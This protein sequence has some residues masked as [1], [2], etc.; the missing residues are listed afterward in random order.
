MKQSEERAR[1][2][3]AAEKAGAAEEEK[4]AAEQKAKELEEQLEQQLKRRTAGMWDEKAAMMAV[5]SAQVDRVGAM[6]PLALVARNPY[7][8]MDL[9]L[10]FVHEPAPVASQIWA[11]GNNSRGQ[12]GL[13]D[14]TDRTTPT[15]ITAFHGK[16]I[17]SVACGFRHTMVVLENGELWATG[18][19]TDAQLG[20][21]DTEN[22]TRP[23]QVMALAG[24]NVVA[25]ACGGYH[26]L[27]M[28]G[29][30]LSC[31]HNR[32]M[33]A[34]THTQQSRDRNRTHRLWRALRLG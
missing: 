29:L 14:T 28:L 33:M 34:H 19:N 20:L 8:V 2:G 22:R 4:H 12:L 26:T 5:L 10:D 1:S 16:R 15:E 3:E 6:S 27:A 30:S 21:G 23:E 17:K 11:W 31:F 18:N 24:K 25:V 7:L 9:C 13:G 32:S